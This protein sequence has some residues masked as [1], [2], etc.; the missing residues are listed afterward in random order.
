MHSADYLVIVAYFAIVV[1]I[2]LR[3]RRSV[4]GSEDF[5][6]SGRS[7]PALVTG[8]A[9]VAANMGSFELMGASATAAKYGMFAV[10]LSWIGCVPAMIFSGLIM[11]RFFYSS[12]ARSVPEYLRLRFDEKTR[13][14][15][16]I[17]FAFLTLFTS[18][19]SLF[20]LAVVFQ[21]LFHWPIDFSIW[22][23]AATVFSYVYLGGLRATIYSEVLQFFLIVA[24][25]VPLSIMI[26]HS[27]GGISGLLARLPQNMAHAWTPLFHPSTS[28]Y[29][30]GL[31]SVTVCLGIASFA[32]WSTDF[33]VVQR[34][35]AAKDLESA[36]STPL[37]AAFPRMLL[38]VLTVVPG[39][40]ALFVIPKQLHGDF[41]MAIPLM[42]IHYYPAG[43]LGVGV[44][45]LLA[46]FMSGMAGNVT[47]FNTV[48]T[49][50]IYQ[51]YIAPNRS[52]RHYLLVGRA[53]T[54][55][56]IL[57][58]IGAA[59]TARGFPNIFDYWALVSTIFV[60]AP[61]ATFVLGVFS[62]NVG[63]TAAF[64]GMLAGILATLSHY[65]LYRLGFLHYGSALEMDFYGGFY[66]FS[67]NIVVTFIASWFGSKPIRQ[68]VEGLV[69]WDTPKPPRT[70]TPFYRTP[71]GLAIWAGVLVIVLNI[72]FW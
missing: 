32:Y 56:G 21:A 45:A 59:Y 41:N 67:T 61:F 48:W 62:R 51:A 31:F 27:V 40:A 54:V 39:L 70:L 3:T 5:F 69:Y 35:L 24:G 10:Q 63:G 9:F 12:K 65:E 13:G 72:I 71:V 23:S 43:L 44:A 18:G 25:T 58:S 20:G 50:D 47:A 19:L 38:P 52:D 64:I 66:G 53:V 7:L 68:Q 1:Y 16:A 14:L 8:I 15:N 2:G 26:F 11:A 36:Q 33:L 30:G 60:A 55:A 42:F 4:H 28:A 46:S 37:I 57:L 22:I 29:G 6:L 34:L 17:N 49:Y